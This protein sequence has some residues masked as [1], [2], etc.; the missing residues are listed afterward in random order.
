MEY[1]W[2]LFALW[3]MLAA[4]LM[5]F[6]K[7]MVLVR[8]YN[9]DTYL[10]TT[11]VIFLAVFWVYALLFWENWFT[12]ELVFQWAVYGLSNFLTPLGMIT[13]YK[14]TS[15]SFSL[16]SI[17]LLA[18][19]FLLIVGMLVMWDQVSIFNIVGFIFWM[20]AIFLLSWWKKW[21]TNNIHIK[22]YVA[23]WLAILSIVFGHSY[24]KY[25]VQDV[26]VPNFMAIQTTSGL[27]FLV[28]YLI[29]RRKIWSVSIREM[30]QVSKYSLVPVILFPTFLLYLLPNLYIYGPLSL[31]YKILS[32][33]IMIPILLSVIFLWE[34]VNRTRTIAFGVTIVSIFLFLV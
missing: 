24:L 8:G 32:Y 2:I 34:P 4:G 22:W 30:L 1:I 5:D 18:S 14:Y 13:A 26:D 33:S 12:R 16:V 27:L 31:G 20:I 17:R 21:E 28:I 25:I 6:N 9:A 19:F 23:I 15:V 7:K 10:L 3:W 11:S 29:V